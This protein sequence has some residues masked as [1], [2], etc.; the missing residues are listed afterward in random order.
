MTPY[1]LRDRAAIVGV[2]MTAFTTDS[3]SSELGLAVEAAKL[4]CD[5]AGVPP[6][7]VDGFASY[8]SYGEGPSPVYVAGFLGNPEPAR[9]LMMPPFG[10]NLTAMMLGFAA[11]ATST[12]TCEYMLIYR[13]INGRSGMRMGG[14]T[15]KAPRADGDRQ[16]LLPFGMHGAPANFA[17]NAREY[18]HR[19]AVRPEDVGA[20]AVTFRDHA[21]RNPHAA[22][23]GRP[24]TL[25]D[26]MSSRP[27]VEPFRLLDC[28]VEVDGAAAILVTSAER[29]ADLRQPSILIRGA[30]YGYRGMAVG[31]PRQQPGWHG[32]GHFVAPRIFECADMTVDAID[33]AG[34]GDDFT[35][36]VLPQL[37][38]FGWCKRGE[39]AAF[40][41][42]GNLRL[43]GAIPCN[44]S[45]G[46]LSEGVMHALNVVIETVVQLRGAAGPRQ[47][48]DAEVALVTGTNGAS[49]AILRRAR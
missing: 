17:M 9:V 49:A 15:A 14:S 20:L 33:V 34:L 10:G 8:N 23:Y 30:A 5:D 37:E 29:A 2:G 31:N 32:S 18:A 4:A 26:Y 24:I 12:G 22:M 47:V 1:A 25:D 41:A 43:G 6:Q 39:G 3:G 42:A 36:S 28:S 35:Y 13:A 21:Q 45:G 40:A 48:P 7:S 46:Q 38:E 11:M 16:Y 44:T 19:Y 27:I